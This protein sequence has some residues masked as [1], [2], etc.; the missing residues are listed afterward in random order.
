MPASL[1][2]E[3]GDYAIVVENLVKRYSGRPVVDGLSFAIRRGEL[4]ALLGPNGAGKTT[5]IEIL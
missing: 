2:S 3:P 1:Q 4:F 5:T